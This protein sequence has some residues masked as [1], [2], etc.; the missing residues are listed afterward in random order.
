MPNLHAQTRFK[1]DNAQQFIG[2]GIDIMRITP[3]LASNA[4]YKDI[5]PFNALS[6]I[7]YARFVLKNAVLYSKF[8]YADDAAMW[9]MIGGYAVHTV[10]PVTDRRTYAPLRTI[11]YWSE[12]IFQGEIEPAL[13]IG[14][15]KNIG[16]KK[17]IIQNI[18][19][20]STVYGLGTNIKGLFR[21]SPR[22]RWYIK[23]LVLGA[24]VEYTRASYGTLNEYGDVVSSIP[25]GNTRFLFATYYIF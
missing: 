15:A 18:G 4:N 11:S 2:A 3:R 23:S 19:D 9:A 1:W 13:F 22:I 5:S 16:A 6:A 8:C 24:E 12:L 21:A 25:I 10:Q 17:P 14:Y 7:V 20:E